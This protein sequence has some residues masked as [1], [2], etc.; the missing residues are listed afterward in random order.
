MT[1]GKPKVH[2]NKNF[3]NFKNKCQ[4]SWCTYKLFISY[5]IL[6][7][8]D[9]WFLKN[10][11]KNLVNVKCKYQNMKQCTDYN[12]AKL[13]VWRWMMGIKVHIENRKPFWLLGL[14]TL[15]SKIQLP[16]NACKIKLLRKITGKLI[17]IHIRK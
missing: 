1:K 2:D 3:L 17:W 5:Y 7:L 10:Y 15:L 14:C 16:Y 8:K 12:E 6:Y 4:N 11:L 13:C 9:S